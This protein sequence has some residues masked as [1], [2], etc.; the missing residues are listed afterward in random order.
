MPHQDLE[1]KIKRFENFLKMDP[2]NMGLAI[3]LADLYV[4]NSRSDDALQ[5]LQSIEDENIFNAEK[6]FRI[7]DLL[8]GE[9]RFDEA[10]ATYK[11]LLDNG[12][13]GAQS[14]HNYALALFHLHR[15]EEALSHL[16]QAENLGMTEDL[17]WKYIAYCNHHLFHL[18]KAIE[19]CKKWVVETRESDESLAYLCILLFEDDQTYEAQEAAL[20]VL[21][22]LPDNIRANTV[23]GSIAL[24]ESRIKEAQMFFSKA[25]TPENDSGRAW[26][27][28]GLA[29]LY[30]DKK[31]EAVLALRQATHA[32]P[33][34]APTIVSL[35][36][37]LLSTAD[38]AS[39]EIEF[40]R[41]IE[42]N[43]NYA[44]AHGGL[45]ASLVHLNRI[46]EAIASIQVAD[47]LDK[48]NF[49]SIYSKSQ[50][51]KLQGKED[52]SNALIE[53]TLETKIPGSSESL[54]DQLRTFLLYRKE[55]PQDSPT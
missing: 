32:M 49:G 53:K 16:T 1:E 31:S 14:H 46:E 47:K 52:E 19:A 21:R 43:R 10:A 55:H 41:A 18:D 40:K 24:Q 4:K 27:G 9:R 20:K 23:M 17:L 36:W 28:Q 11:T 51:L 35:A 29:F 54:L 12:E 13:N 44:E 6:Q 48:Q 38:Y 50:I 26:L 5:L 39:A 37:I 7:A 30:E 25:T 42:V 3:D 22:N 8:L 15:Y 2:K 45:A 34:H 33:N